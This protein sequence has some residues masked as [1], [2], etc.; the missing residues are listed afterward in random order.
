[1][2]VVATTVY[3]GVEKYFADCVASLKRQTM[4]SFK[5]IVADGGAGPEASYILEE[6]GLDYLVS[7]TSTAKNETPASVRK[8]MIEACLNA[9]GDKIVFTD[10]DD[11]MAP[12]C[13][14]ELDRAL[15]S[16]AIVCNELLVFSEQTEDAFPMLAPR[17][18]KESVYSLDD[19]A[20]L[21]FLGMGNT[22]V[23][24][25][26][27]SA[28]Y[29]LPDDD[30]PAYDWALYSLVLKEGGEARFIETAR[31]FYRQYGSNTT[32]VFDYTDEKI[33]SRL[34]TKT[35]HYKFM[36]T[37]DARY[38]DRARAFDK[39]SKALSLNNDLRAQYC[40]LMRIRSP[41]HPLW[42]EIEQLAPE[43]CP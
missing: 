43:I 3:P 2:M 11:M 7:T 41:Q 34:A 6:S 37:V 8:R 25:G 1:M 28:V 10:A 40:Q 35:R 23:Q 18:K 4:A 9:K 15:D 13:L 42:W 39:L 19:I 30:L 26:G 32:S 12:T 14:A 21:N 17:L 33:L 31:T 16:H 29:L 27:L 20:D 38:E 5:F 22:A 24:A 36:A